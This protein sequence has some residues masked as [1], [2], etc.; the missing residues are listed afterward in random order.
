MN[1]REESNLFG[2]GAVVFKALFFV[3]FILIVTNLFSQQI[4]SRDVIDYPNGSISN[5]CSAPGCII[6]LP[7][8]KYG[9]SYSF[10]VPTL[11][12][13][14]RSDVNFNFNKKNTCLEGSINFT[15][16]GR[17][18]VESINS[19]KP[20][21]KNFIE[22]KVKAVSG[23]L[24]DSIDYLLPI[25]RE[26][27]KVVL[28]LDISGS[29]MLPVLGGTEKRWEV[30]KN[31]VDLFT[32]KLEVFKQDGDQIGLTYFST[33]ALQ[34]KSPISSEFIEI[35]S[36]TATTRSSSTIHADMAGIAPNSKTAMGKGLLNVKKKL[37]DNNPID[38]RKIVLLFTDGI[39]NEE[40]LV[41]P[42]G[43]TLTSGGNLLNEGPCNALDSI[44]YYTVGM[45]GTTLAPEMLG[46][47]A[48]ASGGVSL[49][50]PV[51]VENDLEFLMQNQ[52][53]HMLEGGSPQIVS[54]KMGVLSPNGITYSFPVNGNV[55]K[56][57]FELTS[58]SVSGIN[59]KVE[60]DGRDLT[61]YARVNEGSFFKSFSFTLPLTTPDQ[62]ISNGEWLLTITGNS[63]DKYSLVCYV[64]DNFLTF[65]C[66]PAKSVYTVGDKLILKANLSFA[67]RPI[68][69]GA[70]KVSAI[71]FKHGDDLGDL[72]AQSK[73]IAKDSVEDIPSGAETK[74]LTLIQDGKA[75]KEKLTPSSH[76]I[77]LDDDGNGL[78]SAIYDDTELS[79]VYQILFTAS[80]E[81]PGF[82]K[83]ERQKQY[84]A[85]FKFGQINADKSNIKAEIGVK[86]QDKNESIATVTF[87]PKNDFG[88]CLGPG[89]LSRIKLSVDANQGKVTSS[90]DNLDGSYTFII[91]SIPQNTKPDLKIMVM[92]EILYLGKFPS[93][94]LY[95]WQ[96]IVLALLIIA[97]VIRLIFAHT[98]QQFLR[99][100]LW[101]L[102]ILWILFMVLQRLG[103]VAL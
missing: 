41:N 65:N 36:E 69:G 61:S 89:F 51:G 78:Y 19:C 38:A 86:K 26:P 24:T 30:L 72:L 103:I 48:Q 75:F 54:R 34:P 29:M 40:P 5:N 10:T 99:I 53:V 94:K 93:P 13:V 96:F 55:S 70:N 57:Y 59:I 73:I 87:K 66:K 33:D 37:G 14:S 44:R 20:G 35:S 91:S 95:T 64:D 76:T 85:I 42:D 8:I 28:A 21:N 60:K 1:H 84:T 4:I 11:P 52:F 77:D 31:S 32:Q 17:I 15:P 56:L 39:Q 80:G 68:T 12:N 82:G 92:D 45:G 46:K 50:S 98:G 9:Q 3:Y 100:V 62:I 67:G 2:K 88:Y 74:L 7:P 83:F 49:S 79:G 47:I 71:I 58:T 63:T 23:N 97:L 101:V 27:L 90:K 22:I 6:V 102:L 16:D 18:E 81:I 43:V 25:L